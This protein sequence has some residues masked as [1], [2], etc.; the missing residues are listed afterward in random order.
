LD[1]RADV[2]EQWKRL[3]N[4]EL[5]NRYCSWDIIRVNKFRNMRRG[6]YGVRMEEVKNTNSTLVWKSERKKTIRNI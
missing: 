6:G 4:V 5:H 3:Y 2:T 1:Q